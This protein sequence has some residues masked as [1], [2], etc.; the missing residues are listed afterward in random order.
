MPNDTTTA[1]QID[2]MIDGVDGAGVYV[3]SKDV[4][5][6]HLIGKNLSAMKPIVEK[7]IKRLFLDNRKLN[8]NVIWVADIGTFKKQAQET[9]N[10]IA[11]YLK[12]A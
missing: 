3:R 9:P 11:I 2:L 6:L 5:G 8:V 7:A 12:A 4:P 10:K 1:Y